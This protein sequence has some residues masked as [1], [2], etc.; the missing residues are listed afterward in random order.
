MSSILFL[1]AVI[2]F[3][4]VVHWTFVNDRPGRKPARRGLLDMRDAAD[5]ENAPPRPRPRWAQG[6][7]LEGPRKSAFIRPQPRWRRTAQQGRWRA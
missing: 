6:D 3:L 4:I 5:P 1:M 7:Q 2:A